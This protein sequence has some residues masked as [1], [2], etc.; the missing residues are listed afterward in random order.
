[1]WN[2]QIVRDTADGQTQVAA[3]A[4]FLIIF[5]TRLNILFIIKKWRFS[6]MRVRVRKSNQVVRPA[7]LVSRM[8][9][10]IGIAD[11]CCL[12]SSNAYAFTFQ[13]WSWDSTRNSMPHPLATYLKISELWQLAHI[14]RRLMC[15]YQ[16]ISIK[17]RKRK[18]KNFQLCF[19]QS[20][21]YMRISAQRDFGHNRSR[22]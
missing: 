13:L 22:S 16:E 18:G 7:Y 17:K 12:S 20:L 15:W 19:G 6:T 2:T 11:L 8:D 9:W 10:L 14:Q 3:V 21:S 4:I 1:M 5:G